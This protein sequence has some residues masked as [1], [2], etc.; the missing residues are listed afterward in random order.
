[1]MDDESVTPTAVLTNNQVCPRWFPPPINDREEE[2][3]SFTTTALLPLTV[4]EGESGTG[5][6][7]GDDYLCIDGADRPWF[8]DK[9]RK[10]FFYNE[11]RVVVQAWVFYRHKDG[12]WQSNCG[13]GC[14]PEPTPYHKGWGDFDDQQSPLVTILTAMEKAVEA[15]QQT[16]GQGEER[17]K[18]RRHR[19]SRRQPADVLEMPARVN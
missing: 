13:D 17:A 11:P 18:T 3:R 12:K 2:E 14:S 6:I 7:H 9:K 19:G 16:V 4:V 8:F 5:R 1:M 10:V 15:Y